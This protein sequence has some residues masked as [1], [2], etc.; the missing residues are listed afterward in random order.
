MTKD[1]EHFFRKS[2]LIAAADLWTEGN[3]AFSVCGY[4]FPRACCTTFPGKERM[5]LGMR[6]GY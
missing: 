6:E 1:V 3:W 2:S 4:K 5:F